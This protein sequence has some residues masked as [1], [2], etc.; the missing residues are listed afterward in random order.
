M[1]KFLAGFGLRHKLVRQDRFVPTIKNRLDIVEFFVYQENILFSCLLSLFHLWS[2][3]KLL[4]Y[5]SYIT[6]LSRRIS[7]FFNYF[8]GQLSY[9]IF[10]NNYKMTL[11]LHIKELISILWWIS[12]L[13]Y[14]SVASKNFKNISSSVTVSENHQSLWIKE[15]VYHYILHSFIIVSET[16]S[17]LYFQMNKDPFSVPS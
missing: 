6:P 10:N 16:N 14:S 4:Y 7:I 3:H 8:Q 17:Y 5:I 11:C 2:Y 9:H 12:R 15:S 13:I 1:I